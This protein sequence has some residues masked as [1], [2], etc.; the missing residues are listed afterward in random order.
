MTVKVEGKTWTPVSITWEQ[1]GELSESSTNSADGP[2]QKNNGPLRISV[3][4]DYG[5]VLLGNQTWL[6]TR[7]CHIG[8]GCFATPEYSFG[9]SVAGM[10]CL[11]GG[12][13]PKL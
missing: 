13:L 3:E 8:D 1:E 12:P 2:H 6:A 4:G 11:T 5:L 7:S 9:D 10:L